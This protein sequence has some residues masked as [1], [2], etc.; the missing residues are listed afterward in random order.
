V[1]SACLGLSCKSLYNCHFSKHGVVKLSIDDL[2]HRRV[3]KENITLLANFLLSWVPESLRYY[4]WKD[5]VFVTKERFAEVA[6]DWVSKAN[7]F[8][9]DELVY[10]FPGLDEAE[11]KK[12][13]RRYERL[14]R[15]RGMIYES[16]IWREPGLHVSYRLRKKSERWE[17]ECFMRGWY[18][19][20][21]EPEA[22]A[23]HDQFFKGRRWVGAI[24]SEKSIL[25]N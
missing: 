23:F 19:R 13:S 14:L 11:Y 10:D 25:E 12:V 15:H 3:Y 9:F 24:S 18:P 20:S 4:N 6:E 7:D 17:M 5:G 2:R 16:S 1:S 21:I 22:R 8:S